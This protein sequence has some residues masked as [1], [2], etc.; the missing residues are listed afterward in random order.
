MPNRLRRISSFNPRARVGRDTTLSFFFS[1]ISSFNPRA[2]V[3]RDSLHSKRGNYLG[4][5]QST[6]PRGAR[7]ECPDFDPNEDRVSIHAPAWGATSA[8]EQP[9]RGAGVSIHAPAW[10]ATWLVFTSRYNLGSFNPRARVGRDSN[11][12]AH[13]VMLSGFNPRARVGRDIE[14]AAI[15][16]LIHVSI[17]APAWGA[18]YFDSIR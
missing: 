8:G 12:S 1:A 10:G 7:L 2:R 5:F 13:A 3:G 17:H 4:W 6:R 11:G 14:L 18:T 9:R 15:K 16:T